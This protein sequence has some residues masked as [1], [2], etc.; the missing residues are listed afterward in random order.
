MI[1]R[2]N[3]VWLG[4]LGGASWSKFEVVSFVLLQMQ[5]GDICDSVKERGRK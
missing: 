2:V 5:R 4:D 1:R 3:S